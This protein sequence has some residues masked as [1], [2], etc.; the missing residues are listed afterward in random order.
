MGG[1]ESHSYVIVVLLFMLGALYSVKS[2]YIAWC[3]VIYL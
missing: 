1:M 2:K 3:F